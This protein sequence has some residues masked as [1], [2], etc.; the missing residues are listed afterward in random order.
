VHPRRHL[1]PLDQL[2]PGPLEK[3]AVVRDLPVAVQEPLSLG[4]RQLG[5]SRLVLVPVKVRV[6]GAQLVE[7]QVPQPGRA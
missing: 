7:L 5:Q 3:L 4:K 2:E 6:V 1:L